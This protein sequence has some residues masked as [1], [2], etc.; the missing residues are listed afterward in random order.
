MAMELAFNRLK[1]LITPTLTLT[2]NFKV[3]QLLC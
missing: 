3:I 2:I 1:K